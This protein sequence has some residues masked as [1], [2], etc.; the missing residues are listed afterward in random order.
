MYISSSEIFDVFGIHCIFICQFSNCTNI[1]FLRLW[2]L[3]YQI[4]YLYCLYLYKVLIQI[5][6]ELF[7][8]SPVSPLSDLLELFKFDDLIKIVTYPQQQ[9]KKVFDPDSWDFGYLFPS[10]G[11][12][13][14][15]KSKFQ[16]K[17]NTHTHI[18]KI[19]F[20]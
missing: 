2:S 17:K 8:L 1:Q 9:Q 11:I 7:K 15:I 5:G 6:L 3:S 13:I 19:K 20:Q 18:Y 4:V 10:S 12:Q 16:Q 14:H